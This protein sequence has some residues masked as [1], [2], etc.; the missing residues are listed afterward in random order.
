M[1]GAIIITLKYRRASDFKTS[2]RC[3]NIIEDRYYFQVHLAQWVSPQ[4]SVL[5]TFSLWIPWPR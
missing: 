1:I 4:R 2:L 3:F 5:G